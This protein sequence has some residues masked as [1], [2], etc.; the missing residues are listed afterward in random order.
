MPD[1]PDVGN[2][3]FIE[4][5]VLVGA[6]LIGGSFALALK[7][8]ALVETLP[9][10]VY[11]AFNLPS[12]AASIQALHHPAPEAN[13]AD[14]ENHSTLEWRRLA[15]DELLAQQLSLRKL[16]PTHEVPIQSYLFLSKEKSSDTP[17]KRNPDE[18]LRLRHEF[19]RQVLQHVSDE[20]VDD[21]GHCFFLR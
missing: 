3:A 2:Q 9:T 15:F 1:M 8:D 4:R 16:R 21:Q 18:L 11:R 6:G 12:F 19:H 10:G 20:A 13:L 17:L 5:L 7:Q 14:L